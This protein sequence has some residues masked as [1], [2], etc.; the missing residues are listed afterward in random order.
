MEVSKYIRIM[1]LAP[2]FLIKSKCIIKNHF[3]NLMMLNAKKHF[4][5]HSFMTF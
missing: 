5:S 2:I 3:Q 1:L 4:F